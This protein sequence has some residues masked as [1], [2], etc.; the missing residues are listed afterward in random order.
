M[1]TRQQLVEDWKAKLAASSQPP[2]ECG[3]RFAWVR[4]VYARIYRFLISCY[5][6]GEWRGAGDDSSLN[7]DS[8]STV[9][10]MPFVECVPTSDGLL[11][12]SPERIRAAL[13]SIHG[14]NPGIATPGTM[15]GVSDDAWV[16]VAAR[17]YLKSARAVHRRL[18]VC[19]IEAR[20][21]NRTTDTAIVVRYGEFDQAL[22]VIERVGRDK[23]IRIRIRRR[24]NPKESVGVLLLILSV[25]TLL[26][27]ALVS[28]PSQRIIV[29]VAFALWVVGLVSGWFAIRRGKRH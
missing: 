20:L 26:G 13:E 12:K 14:S 2:V 15:T 29:A 17:K 28:N 11:P 24:V 19:G 9:S 22:E 5:G 1:D 8:Q 16:V 21:Q 6:E 18:M 3:E 27:L 7:A 23:Q 10:R 25:L 4:Q